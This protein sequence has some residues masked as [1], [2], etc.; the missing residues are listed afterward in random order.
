MLFEAHSNLDRFSRSQANMQP[1]E[2][3]FFILVHAQNVYAIEILH[4]VDSF[5][6][7]VFNFLLYFWLISLSF[8]V[9]INSKS[10]LNIDANINIHK[11]AMNANSLLLIIK[12][13]HRLFY[14]LFSSTSSLNM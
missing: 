7:C 13:L 3:L 6:Q 4:L 2:T 10:I 5:H 12:K 1:I 8:K 14:D 11:C 9:S